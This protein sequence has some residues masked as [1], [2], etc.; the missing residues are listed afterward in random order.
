ML[1]DNC[2]VFNGAVGSLLGDNALKAKVGEK[3]RIFFGDGGPNKISSFHVIGEIFD[4][5]YPE[6]ASE[7]VHNVQTTL[8]PPGGGAIVEFKIE[9]P[10]TYVLVDHAISRVERGAIGQLV[11]KGPDAPEVYNKLR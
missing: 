5:V 4:T 6:A 8:V 7:P 11:A 9:V 10:G 3:V 1:R 2:L